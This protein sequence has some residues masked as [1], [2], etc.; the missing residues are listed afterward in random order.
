M[1]IGRVAGQ[2]AVTP[3]TACAGRR[4]TWWSSSNRSR[5]SRPRSR[6]PGGTRRVADGAEQDR[7]VLAQL[8][9]HRVRQQLAGAL[10]ARGTQVV[11]RGLDVGSDLAED[12][13]ALGHHLGTDPVTGDHCQRAWGTSTPRS[14]RRSRSARD[15]ASRAAD[16]GSR[17]CR[18]SSS[19]GTR[20]VDGRR[21]MS[22]LAARVVRLT[23][24]PAM[25]M[26]ASPS[27]APTV[28]T[29]PGPVGVA[30]EQQVARQVQVHVEPV[31]LDQLG[32]LVLAEQRAGHGDL[33]RRRPSRRAA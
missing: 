24:A 9:E 8:L 14:A 23:W 12:L 16:P 5:S 18:P 13:E 7:V 6:M 15:R 11:V 21:A 25:L 19:G 29:T 2:R 30:E 32:H 1:S 31:D 17:R 27:T 28:P 20:L 3:G 10:P 33:A 26:P 4:F 22:G